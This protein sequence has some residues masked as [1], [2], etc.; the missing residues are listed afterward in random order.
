M[1]WLKMMLPPRRMTPPMGS[2]VPTGPGI[3]AG[4]SQPDSSFLDDSGIPQIDYSHLNDNVMMPQSIFGSSR[5]AR[6][7]DNALLSAAS[8]QP[9]Q[10]TGENISAVAR[11][12]LGVDP[13]RQQLNLSRQMSPY[14]SMEPLLKMKSEMSDMDYRNALAEHARAMAD[15]YRQGGRSQFQKPT[16]KQDDQ[17]NYFQ[18]ASDGNATPVTQQQT[19]QY[20]IPGMQVGGMQ[21]PPQNRSVTGPAQLT[22]KPPGRQGG[23]TAVERLIDGLEQDQ[24]ANGGQPFSAQDRVNLYTHIAGQT[25]GQQTGARIDATPGY[26]EE[27]NKLALQQELSPVDAELDRLTKMDSPTRLIENAMATSTG[28]KPV[29]QRIQDLTTQRK[30]ILNRYLPTTQQLPTPTGGGSNQPL[31]AIP[32]PIVNPATDQRGDTPL[33]I[34]GIPGMA[35]GMTNQQI[36]QTIKPPQ[37]SAATAPRS[38]GRSRPKVRIAPDG[39]IHVE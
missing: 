8:F 5:I 35:H 11:N 20:Q 22:G 32:Q 13:E 39:T 30:S 12:I 37:Q 25:T 17:G 3:P 10:T 14:L 2:S 38:P 31:P 19:S 7:L 29:E 33:N 21:L 26:M 28:Q 36:A 1:S 15:Y 27:Q 34:G 6:G 9:G 16:I 24:I 4:V 23:S 18:I